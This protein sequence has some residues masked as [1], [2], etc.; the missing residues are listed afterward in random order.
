MNANW[1]EI[2]AAEQRASVYS[3]SGMA[4][5]NVKTCIDGASNHLSTRE[6]DN[7][8]V[9]PP[10]DIDKP[11]SIGIDRNKHH[12]FAGNSITGFDL[13]ERSQNPA[14][15]KAVEGLQA[16]G[17]VRRKPGR[18][19]ATLSMSC[20]DKIASW[21]VLGVQGSLLSQV[22]IE[23]IYI[24]SITVSLGS[25]I[26]D[27]KKAGASSDQENSDTQEC[28]SLSKPSVGVDSSEERD[29]CLNALRRSLYERLLPISTKIFPPYLLNLPS[30]WIA[31][32]PSKEL[33]RKTDDTK[34]PACGF[35][36][37]WN[38]A[39]LHEVILGTTGRKQG[40]SAKGAL[41][42]ATRS[43]LSRRALLELYISMQSHF[44]PNLDITRFS[45]REL[46]AAS[47]PYFKAK[48]TLLGLPP[49]VGW[50]TKPSMFQVFHVSGG[51]QSSQ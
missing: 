31:P 17:M 29:Q 27:G 23:P 18:G 21:N 1:K 22:L 49:F 25:T 6:A 10:R 40:T 33:A 4:R 9:C 28:F 44:S 51:E 11:S 37:S 15:Y 38:S 34:K 16:V 46:K 50:L 41:S 43:A 48:N 39:G 35:S 19:D 47:E 32:F 14:I 42:P 12:C 5:E 45:Y 26:T 30:F 20:S 3:Y 36:V 13:G 7:S 8:H 2:C 24:S